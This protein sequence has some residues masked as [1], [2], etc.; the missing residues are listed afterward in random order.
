MKTKN[1]NVRKVEELLTKIPKNQFE[2]I[3]K[4]ASKAET[5]DDI[6]AIARDYKVELTDEQAA[7]LMQMYSEEIALPLDY[8]ESVSGGDS[9]SRY[10]QSHCWD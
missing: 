7:L 8:L 4:A 6:K 9:A 3:V 10:T 1:D 5:A 2:D